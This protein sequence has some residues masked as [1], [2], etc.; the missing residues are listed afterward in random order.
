[1]FDHLK[2]KNDV[3]HPA[4]AFRKA[5][6]QPSLDKLC[7]QLKLDRQLAT[8][9]MIFADFELLSEV[10]QLQIDVAP[11][12]AALNWMFRLDE[13]LKKMDMRRFRKQ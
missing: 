2:S 4:P 1:M 6:C 9:K 13:L 11:Y 12:F 5:I 7:Q 3:R 10:L 8:D